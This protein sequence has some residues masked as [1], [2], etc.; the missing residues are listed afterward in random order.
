MIATERREIVAAPISNLSIDGVFVDFEGFQV[1]TFLSSEK[2]V[3]EMQSRAQRTHS[4]ASH[5]F[6]PFPSLVASNSPSFLTALP[7]QRSDQIERFR[8]SPNNLLDVL[9]LLYC[10]THLLSTMAITW[11]NLR[12]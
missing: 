7:Q 10:N 12:N 6:V 11:E 8:R 2:R 4:L 9:L 1:Q 5:D 3:I